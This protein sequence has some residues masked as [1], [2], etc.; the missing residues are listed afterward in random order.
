[1]DNRCKLDTQIALAALATLLTVAVAFAEERTS[2]VDIPYHLFWQ[3]QHDEIAIQNYRFVSALTQWLPLGLLR[4]ELPMSVVQLGYSLIFVGVYATAYAVTQYG[5]RARAIALAFAGVWLVFATHTHYWI[6]SELPQGLAVL[7]VGLGVVAARGWWTGRDAPRLLALQ[8]AFVTVAFAHPLLVVPTL[9][10]LGLLLLLDRRHLRWA[11]W[12]AATYLAAYGARVIW[13]STPYDSSAGGGLR[14]ALT[15]LRDGRLPY[16]VSHFAQQAF[17]GPYFAFAAVAALTTY[18]FWRMKRRLLAGYVVTGVTAHLGLVALSY[19]GESVRDF[20]IENLYLPAGW[21][22]C[23][24][25]A[26]AWERASEFSLRKPLV[27]ALAGVF[28]L[29]IAVIFYTGAALYTPRLA[30]LKSLMAEHRGEKVLIRETPELVDELIMT[31][32]VSYEAWVVSAREGRA[33]QGLIVAPDPESYRW[34]LDDPDRLVL[35][36]SQPTFAEVGSP[37]VSNPSAV[38]YVVKVRE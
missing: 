28:G 33:T 18:T 6:Q 34:A 26:Y 22:A 19:P 38:P 5:L 27:Y 20:Y 37:Y 8:C 9:F 36:F 23:L 32:G 3:A 29:R 16:S 21:M 11:G 24:A 35:Y 25:A 17:A 15:I 12:A 1:M 7:T 4:L 31:W 14:D 10:A 30:T 2:F 13:F